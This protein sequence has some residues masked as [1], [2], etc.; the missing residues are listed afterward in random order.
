[1]HAFRSLL[2][3]TSLLG[4]TILTA[5]EPSISLP[6][7]AEAARPLGVG[8]KAPEVSVRNV[9]G[10]MVGLGPL[11]ALKPT[12]LIF[13]RGSW[14]PYCNRHLAALGKIEPQLL[15][16][17][18]QILAVSPD[19]VAGLRTAADKNKLDYQLFSDREM[20]AAAA[21]GVAFR[22]SETT[23]KSYTSHGIELAPIS[24]GDGYWLPVPAVYLVGRDGV[25]RFA[26]T[27]ADYKARL[28]PAELLAA[29]AAVATNKK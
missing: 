4:S 25:I 18:Y 22:V 10:A 15:A 14:C 1:M 17:G 2:L 12:V 26:H 7:S 21:F 23:A 24:N 28:G 11:F 20:Q 16:L 6:V 27:N 8:V 3:A 29:A 19:T 9:D 5:A 13:Y